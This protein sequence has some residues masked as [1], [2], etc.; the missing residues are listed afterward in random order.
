MKSKNGTWDAG[1]K[2]EM[3]GKHF[4][5][6]FLRCCA[7]E[8]SQFIFTPTVLQFN[9]NCLYLEKNFLFKKNKQVNV[10]NQSVNVLNKVFLE[11]NLAADGFLQL[12]PVSREALFFPGCKMAESPGYIIYSVEEKRGKKK[13]KKSMQYL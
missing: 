10:G 6:S 12:S 9:K 13:K 2:K 7:A 1:K 8:T 3:F 5:G 4:C 11:F